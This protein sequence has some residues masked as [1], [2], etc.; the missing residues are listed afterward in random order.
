MTA[1][2]AW[3]PSD[4]N[5][6]ELHARLL[7]AVYSET[8]WLLQRRKGIG[9]S[10]CAPALGMSRWEGATPYDVWLDKRGLVPLQRVDNEAAEWGQLL[11]P[12]IRDRA[13]EKLGYSVSTVGSLQ[14]RTH[15]W[16][17]ASL[18]AVLDVPGDGSIPLECKNT[19]Q[20]LA[21]DWSDDQVPDAAELQVQHQMA[22]TG[23]PYAYVAGLVGGN[24]LMLRRVERSPR[25]IAHIIAEEEA[26]W[27]HITEGVQP[28]IVARDN[29]ATIIA[30]AGLA[31]AKELVVGDEQAF[32][33]RQ[34]LGQYAEAREL[35]QTA[36]RMKR[37][38]R[39][40]LA[41]LA[42]GHAEVL[43]QNADATTTLLYR[44]Q[45]GVF[46]AK[47]FQT[48]DPDSAALYMKKVEVVDTGALRNEDP[49]LFRKYQSVSIRPAKAKQ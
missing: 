15:P 1:A 7:P 32:V 42:A 38:A 46:A 9:A 44:L 34:W 26:L 11:E 20:Y 13:A 19:S 48:E 6:F 8:E 10:D 27:W 18:D 2:D 25:L 35:E 45:R 12:V 37:E 24:R 31:D 3:K 17:F 16:Q 47:K 36:D 39:N 41:N 29:L 23:A 43:E 5:P 21:T 4:H 49:D 40:N 30:A 22:V 28:P 14:S 33:I